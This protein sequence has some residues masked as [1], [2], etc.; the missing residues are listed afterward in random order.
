MNVM[1]LLTM[2]TI[3]K[4]LYIDISESEIKYTLDYLLGDPEKKK[5]V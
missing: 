4:T 2:K 1:H 5:K 3:E